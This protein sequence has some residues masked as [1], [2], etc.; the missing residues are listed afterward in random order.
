[1]QKSR[2][3]PKVESRQVSHE[4]IVLVQDFDKNL[5]LVLQVLLG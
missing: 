4:D 5:V 2:C 1:M 3:D